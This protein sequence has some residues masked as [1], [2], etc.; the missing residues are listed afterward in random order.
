[1]KAPTRF[2]SVA[3]VILALL[4]VISLTGCGGPKTYTDTKYKFSLEYPSSMSIDN[5]NQT[6]STEAVTLASND[7]TAF[8]NVLQGVGGA[9]LLSEDE[10]DKGTIS[11]DQG[12]TNIKDQATTLG[13]QPAMQISYNTG[14][15]P[16]DFNQV[17][18][19]IKDG[20][21]YEL[22]VDSISGSYSK[23]TDPYPKMKASFK[24][25]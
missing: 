12:N 19:T 17:V 5:G 15:D 2:V 25:L 11:S 20:K 3:T 6:T 24:F 10:A 16:K 14:D 21:E 22:E 9:S 23:T 13:G 7:Y 1:M 8:V 18:F 4:V